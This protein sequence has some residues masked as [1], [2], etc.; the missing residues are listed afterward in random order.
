M[1]LCAVPTY[2]IGSEPNLVAESALLLDM[3]TGT[4]LYEK[5]AD[6]RR[7]PASMTK[8]MTC[9]LA[10]ENMDLSKYITVKG[11]DIRGITGD[12]IGLYAGEEMNTGTMLSAM[13]V[14]SGN[15]AAVVLATEMAGSVEAFAEMMNAKAAQIGMTDTH[16]VNPNGL[17][18][19]EQYTTARDMAK[20]A[21]YCM[22]N[23]VFRRI[24]SRSEFT[25]P[26]TNKTSERHFENTNAL[27][28][29][30]K[31]KYE[32]CIGIKTGTTTPAGGC[33][34]AAVTRGDT[35]LLSIVMKS[36][37]EER[38]SDSIA[39]FDYGFANFKTVSINAPESI[40]ETVKVKGGKEKLVAINVP[41]YKNIVT[42]SSDVQSSTL[43]SKVVLAETIEAPVKVGDVVGHLQIVDG[44][45]VVD[46]Y[47]IT[48]ASDIEA[49]G[50][51]LPNFGGGLFK[52]ILL[53][54]GIVFISLIALIA[55]YVIVQ[56]K[57]TEKRKAA[58]AARRAQIEEQEMQLR[59]EWEKTYHGRFKD[60]L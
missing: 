29:D 59:K 56:R 41:S 33:L 43:E 30:G 21:T 16:F 27:L 25:V 5:D 39:L 15:D 18:D 3:T 17:H 53:I 46:E 19:E 49:K 7:Y 40:P 45:K 58:R 9:I 32:G 50:G 24:V 47:D 54:I 37:F 8:M 55:I 34:A 22:Q 31:Y 36:S 23:E 60:E 28:L 44:D 42:I 51:A 14:I 13:M 26:V 57:K 12:K 1:L 2:A 11:A 4:V 38:F 10:L 52:K 20:L 48:A 6:S 35:T